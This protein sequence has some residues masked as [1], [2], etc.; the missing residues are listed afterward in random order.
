MKRFPSG[1][2]DELGFY[3]Y[4][5][6]NPLTEPI[7]YIDKGKNNRCFDH[8]FVSTKISSFASVPISLLLFVRS[9]F[10]NNPNAFNV[11]SVILSRLLFAKL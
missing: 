6:I 10:A 11:G 8:L 3:V 1:V 5:Y 2:A 7:F 9:V 4:L